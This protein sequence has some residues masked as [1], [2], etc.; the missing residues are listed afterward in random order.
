M[1]NSNEEGDG[2]MDRLHYIS[3]RLLFFFLNGRGGDTEVGEGLNH[4]NPFP[5]PAFM[6][7][8]LLPFLVSLPICPCQ[9]T[10][11]RKIGALHCEITPGFLVK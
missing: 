11:V 3:V 5:P 10:H 2:L 8:L 4:H 6:S 1:E 7:P 9:T